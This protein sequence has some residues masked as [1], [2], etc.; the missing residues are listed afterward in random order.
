[1]VDDNSDFTESV[2]F[3]EYNT[4]IRKKIKTPWL[5]IIITGLVTAILSVITGI[6]ASYVLENAFALNFIIALYGIPA[7]FI[8]ALKNKTLSFLIS[9]QYS[10]Y[11]ALIYSAGYFL[12]GMINYF[13]NPN[14]S[15]GQIFT[16]L[17]GLFLT[18]LVIA[19]YSVVFTFALGALFGTMVLGYMD[20]RK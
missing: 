10:S 7:G 5:R 13:I 9:F 15:V 6:F 3:R 4:G 2:A 11:S 1:M 19:I 8:V 17:G 16:G 12:F 14:I 20:D 18:C